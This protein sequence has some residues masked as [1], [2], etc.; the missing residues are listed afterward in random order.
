MGNTEQEKFRKSMQV[1]L[2]KGTIE[3][4]PNSV[5]K[6]IT[7]EQV[8]EL[9]EMVKGTPNE[10][11][12]AYQDPKVRE[13]VDY[14]ISALLLECQSNSAPGTSFPLELYRRYK[15]IDSLR[16]KIDKVRNYY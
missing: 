16:A 11:L 4:N 6:D 13:L 7:I 8:N 5:A 2:K 1:D 10:V 14:V 9:A 12:I 15:S 3:Y